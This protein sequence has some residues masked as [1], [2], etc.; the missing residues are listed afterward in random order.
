MF[1]SIHVVRSVGIAG[2]EFRTMEC[3]SVCGVRV[4]RR[5]VDGTERADR[6]QFEVSV[7][8]IPHNAFLYVRGDDQF[9]SAADGRCRH[10]A[11]I[12][13]GSLRGVHLGIRFVVSS[14][15]PTAAGIAD[16]S[17]PR[18]DTIVPKRIPKIILHL[19]THMEA[20]VHIALLPPLRNVFRERNR[21]T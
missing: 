14:F 4:H 20:L 17:H 9:G 11:D 19:F 8:T 5:I 1:K 21:G 7:N 3:L 10:R 16:L 2:I 13:N 15:L 12:A 6:V 18:E